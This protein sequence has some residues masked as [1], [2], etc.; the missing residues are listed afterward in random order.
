MPGLARPLRVA[1]KD[2]WYPVTARG[3]ERRAVVAD[4]TNRSRD[5]ALYLARKRYGMR[6]RELAV[7]AGG[8]GL[9]KH[10]RGRPP[11]CTTAAAG[12]ATGCADAARHEQIE[13]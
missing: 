13:E 1:I 6:L 4:D 3:N 12:Q 8:L 11:V 5:V 9:R 7:A 10:Q 2:G